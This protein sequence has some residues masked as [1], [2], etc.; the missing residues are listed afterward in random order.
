MFSQQQ[1]FQITVIFDLQE[2][3][4]RSNDRYELQEGK[5]ADVSQKNPQSA[6]N[7]NLVDIKASLTMTFVSINAS[8]HCSFMFSFHGLPL[9]KF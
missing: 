8:G 1:S 4:T 9:S 2:N 6:L 7:K 3:I 5:N